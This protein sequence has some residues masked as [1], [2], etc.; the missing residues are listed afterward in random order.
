[1]KTKTL[2]RFK[3]MI[4]PYWKVI[5]VVTILSIIIDL[6]ELVKPYIIQQI[7]DNFLR[8]KNN[9]FN[10]ITIDQMVIFYVLLVIFGNVIDYINRCVSYNLGESVVYN[11]RLKLFKFIEK[12][13]LTFHDKTPSGK[14]Y[15]R[16][17]SDTEDVYSLFTDVI[18]TLPKDLI[19]IFSLIGMMIYLSVKLSIINVFMIIF[20]VFT[21][22]IITKQMNKIFSDSKNKRTKLNTF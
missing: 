17:T 8:E 13:N 12:A 11:L 10:N 18:T 4:K 14:L 5:I 2:S 20:L 7:I 9:I 19:L 3:K 1:M 6:A 16:V 15:V 22:V 21:T